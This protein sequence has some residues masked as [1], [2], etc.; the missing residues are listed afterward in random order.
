MYILR[1]ECTSIIENDDAVSFTFLKYCESIVEQNKYLRSTSEMILCKYRY[2]PRLQH[3]KWWFTA[4]ENDSGRDKTSNQIPMDFNAD[5]YWRLTKC[6]WKK[7]K[8]PNCLCSEVA[9]VA[10]HDWYI[11]VWLNRREQSFKSIKR[12]IYLSRRSIDLFDDQNRS[13]RILIPD[14]IAIDIEKEISVR[15][16]PSWRLIETTFG[17]FSRA[18]TKRPQNSIKLPQKRGSFRQWACKRSIPIN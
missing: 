2:Y 17:R 7:K 11:C 10:Q 9:K 13:L 5:S 4:H 3:S 6:W 12:R 18:N 15:I 14:A 1:C 16:A 8:T